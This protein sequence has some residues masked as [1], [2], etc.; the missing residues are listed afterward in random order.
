MSTNDLPRHDGNRPAAMNLKNPRSLRVIQTLSRLVT[1]IFV[2]AL[3]WAI[4]QSFSSGNPLPLWAWL[5]ILVLLAVAIG[6]GVAYFVYHGVAKEVGPFDV[7]HSDHVAGKL[8]NEIMR[9]ETG[10][11]RSLYTE[12][13]MAAGE[14]QLMG[15]AVETMEGSF[16]YDD[17]DWKP[18]QLSYTVNDTGQGNLIVKQSSTHR[19]AM[20]QGRCEWTIR[21]NENLP[22][23]L[24]VKFGAGRALLRPTDLMLTRLRIE[25]GVGKLVLDLSGEWQQSME[26]FVKS[27]IGDIVLLLPQTA[28]IRI[29]TMVELGSIHPH[30]LTWDGK[31]FT[32][33]LF[34]EAPANLDITIE[35]GI[36]KLILEEQA[37]GSS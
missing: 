6:L 32:N 24:K 28:G 8:K 20:R 30:N 29:N 35:G 3:I 15:G 37:K 5:G 4:Y 21:L 16:T 25:S 1:A 36:G 18:P 34:G 11:A 14:L 19:P 2:L 22:T 33:S 27:G 12:I 7:S 26:A 10:G 13:I 31:A 9:V 17:A 23:E